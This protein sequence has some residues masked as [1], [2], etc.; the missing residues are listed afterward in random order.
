[1]FMATPV[2]QP[3]LGMARMRSLTTVDTDGRSRSRANG[4]REK[5]RPGKA[6]RMSGG[7]CP[8]PT[9]SMVMRMTFWRP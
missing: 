1:M 9:P 2:K 8:G 5:G 4:G 3:P 6:G 7:G